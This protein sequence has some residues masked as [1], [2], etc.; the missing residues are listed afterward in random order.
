M[1]PTP[2]GQLHLGNVCAFAAAWMSA[3]AQ[4]GKLLLRVEDI[5]TE[6]ARAEVA[7]DQRRELAWLGLDW[8]EE[9]PPQSSRD[10]QGALD[11]IQARTYFCECTRAQIQ[12]TGG[13]YRGTCRERGLTQ[14]ALRFWLP[15]GLVTFVDRR[16][17]PQQEDPNLFGDPVLRRR[18]GVYSYNLAV[19]VDDIRDGVTEVVR[20]AD[21]LEYSAVQIRLW[22]AWGV[23]PP[24]WL[25]APLILGVDGSKLSKSHNSLHVG[26]L[27]ELGWTPRDI[28]RAV[29]PWLG[30]PGFDHLHDAVAHFRPDAGP[31]GPV[32]L[33]LGQGALPS[34]QQ[35]LTWSVPL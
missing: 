13:T 35:G 12:A 3:R 18:D 2:S 31:L 14:G 8:D 23:K 16:W 4:R 25:H 29:L 15:E 9:T 28:W 11:A 24:T 26:A 34:P 19:V 10:Y 21:L 27:R 1:A 22:E 17:G 30:L 32:V 20:G 6:R 7:Q 5:D 33:H